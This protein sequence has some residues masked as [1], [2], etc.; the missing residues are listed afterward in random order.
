MRRLHDRRP[1]RA[2]QPRFEPLSAILRSRDLRRV[3]HRAASARPRNPAVRRRDPPLQP[4]ATRLFSPIG[5]GTTC[6][7]GPP[8]RTTPPLVTAAQRPTGAATT[9]PEDNRPSLEGSPHVQITP[10]P[11]LAR[12][13]RHRRT[14][15]QPRLAA[16]TL[17]C[18]DRRPAPPGRRPH[19]A[20]GRQRIQ[21]RLPQPQ[22][23]HPKTAPT[24]RSP[25]HRHIYGGGFEMGANTRPPRTHPGSPRQ[26]VPSASR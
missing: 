8:P 20:R 7:L 14:L 21:R 5:D 26:A 23:G 12:R 19:L 11:L 9:P 6:S 24:N 13:P 4:R 18:H 2:D 17:T 25:A 10:H 22:R 15:P 16:S 1:S 3:F